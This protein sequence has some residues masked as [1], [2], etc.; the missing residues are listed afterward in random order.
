LDKGCI[1]V[2]NNDRRRRGGR[3]IRQRE[4]ARQALRVPFLEFGEVAEIE[5]AVRAGRHTRRREAKFEKVITEVA[6]CSGVAHRIEADCAIGAREFAGLAVAAAALVDKDDSGLRLPDRVRGAGRHAYRIEAVMA[7]RGQVVGRHRGD[8]SVVLPLPVS[9]RH[10]EDLAP[11]N[12]DRQVVLVFACD[13]A[14]LASRA[15]I[16]IDEK[17]VLADQ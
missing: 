2:R 9:G 1:A 7:G 3:G 15:G 8:P 6:F 11:E 17:C 16:R 14:R 5:R 13:L 4:Y 12:A 10:L